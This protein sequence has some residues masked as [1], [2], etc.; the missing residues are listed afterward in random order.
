[1]N[2]KT[3]IRT[4]TATN[5]AKRYS[6]AEHLITKGIGRSTLFFTY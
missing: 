6:I 4:K 2:E 1:M 3:S 5:A